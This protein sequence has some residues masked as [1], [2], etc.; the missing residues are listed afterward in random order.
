MDSKLLLS[1]KENWAWDFWVGCVVVANKVK[2]IGLVFPEN[3]KL[4]GGFSFGD[5]TGKR[6]VF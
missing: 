4:F 1:G 5:W 2:R 6:K 3:K